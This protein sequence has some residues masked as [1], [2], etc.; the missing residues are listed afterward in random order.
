MTTHETG[1][2]AAPI[3]GTVTVTET[4]TGTHTQSPAEVSPA[5]E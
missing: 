5:A 3:E 4:G 2:V 1:H